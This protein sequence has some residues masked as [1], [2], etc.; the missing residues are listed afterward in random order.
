MKRFIAYFGTL[1]GGRIVLWSYLI[2]YLVTVATHFDP[3]PR[4]WLTSLGLSAIIGVALWISTRSSSTGTTELD[5]WQILQFQPPVYVRITLGAREAGGDLP[6]GTPTHVVLNSLSGVDGDVQMGLGV[7]VPT[8]FVCG[9]STNQN[10]VSGLT[11]SAPYQPGIY[12]ARV[13]DV[14]NLTGSTAFDV[15]IA[16]P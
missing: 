2:W 9:T 15:S 1:T 6:V 14:G 7:G 12:C 16:H 4:L 11:L 5:R 8:G 13:T 10:G 3:R